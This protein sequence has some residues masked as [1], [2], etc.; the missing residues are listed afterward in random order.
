M[1]IDVRKEKYSV[2]RREFDIILRKPFRDLQ[3]RSEDID[4]IVKLVEDSRK[5]ESGFNIHFNVSLPLWR[6]GFLPGRIE[7]EEKIQVA[8]DLLTKVHASFGSETK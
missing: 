1:E 3:S 7:A 4:C 8:R 5:V 6:I 2:R